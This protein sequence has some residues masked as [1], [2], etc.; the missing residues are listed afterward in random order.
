MRDLAHEV[1]LV[2]IEA[3]ISIGDAPLM[4]DETHALGQ[5]KIALDD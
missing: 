3:S 4:L 5:S 1:V 2:L